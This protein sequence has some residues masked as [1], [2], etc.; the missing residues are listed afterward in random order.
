MGNTG[1]PVTRSKTKRKPCLVA[2]ATAS[3]VRPPRRIVTS[4]GGDGRS[5]S[6]VVA[7]DLE[8]PDALARGRVERDER[9]GK[10]IVAQPV[11]PIEVT[12]GRPGRHIDEA[13]RLVER[14][15]GPAVGAAAVLPGAL[16]PRGVPEFARMRNGVEGPAQRARPHVVGA[17]VTRGGRQPLADAAADDHQILVDDSGRRESHALR[18]RIAAEILAQVDPPG[19]AEG[20]ERLSR[21]G[22]ERVN[23]VADSGKDAPIA[24]LRPVHHP[25]VRPAPADAGVEL[26]F[27]DAGGGVDGKQL[28]GRGVAVEDVA[29][30][31]GLR[32]QCARLAG[33]VG[34]GDFELLHVGAVDLRQRGVSR[35]C[36]RSAVHPRG[37]R[38]GCGRRDTEG[39]REEQ[40]QC[41]FISY[42]RGFAPRTP[43]HALSRAA[44][45]A[46]GRV[47]RSL[48]LAR[49]ALGH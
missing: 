36:G 40:P 45:G 46:L 27:P 2:C 49:S 31:E 5:R 42:P 23:E 37:R 6:H 9:I 38:D 11:G 33:V 1:S 20:I 25:A 24:A 7:D 21:R 44:A 15:P 4:V 3:I 35:L 28:V 17:N 14:H 22:V 41:R 47:A 16:R 13:P 30:D 18:L 19:G 48:T 29:D 32:L 8:V 10:Q 39:A 26:P 43:R 34:P 12:R